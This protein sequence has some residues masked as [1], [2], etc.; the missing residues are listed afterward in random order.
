MFLNI[1][2]IFN[3]I[4]TLTKMNKNG[5]LMGLVVVFIFLIIGFFWF[6]GNSGLENGLDENQT[7]NNVLK[8]YVNETCV[9]ASC[10]HAKN[11]VL[12]SV[13]PDCSDVF[14]TMECHAGTMDCGQGSCVFRNGKCEVNWK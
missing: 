2:N 5:F 8:N 1:S 9:P 12:E 7:L 4:I 14:C 3:K 13:A 11:C 6:T 10:C